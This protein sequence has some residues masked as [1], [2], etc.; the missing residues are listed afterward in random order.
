MSILILKSFSY[1]I[2]RVQFPVARAYLKPP[3]T[4]FGMGIVRENQE[5]IMESQLFVLVSEKQL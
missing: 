2:A 4:Q 5:K 3:T 1:D